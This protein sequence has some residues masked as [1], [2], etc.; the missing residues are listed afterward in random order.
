MSAYT[1]SSFQLRLSYGTTDN[2][3]CSPVKAGWYVDDLQLDT[4]Q[5]CP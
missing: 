4:V 2:Y 1:T 5:A 3:A